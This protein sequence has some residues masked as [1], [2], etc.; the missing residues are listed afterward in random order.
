MSSMISSN[1]PVA[2]PNEISRVSD[3]SKGINGLVETSSERRAAQKTDDVVSISCLPSCPWDLPSGFYARANGTPIYLAGRDDFVL[4]TE[5][6][7]TTSSKYVELGSRICTSED[8]RE[9]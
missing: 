7:K 2:S 1:V 9:K 5:M 6:F 3:P 4:N 8:Q